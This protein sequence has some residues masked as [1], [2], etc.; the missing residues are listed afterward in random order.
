MHPSR[1]TASEFGLL[2]AHALRRS[3]PRRWNRQ[4]KEQN[5]PLKEHRKRWTPNW[6]PRESRAETRVVTKGMMEMAPQIL[7]VCAQPPRRE[8]H[9]HA[10][11]WAPKWRS[12]RPSYRIAPWI[13]IRFSPRDQFLDGTDHLRG[14]WHR[15]SPC[16]ENAMARRPPDQRF[17][18]RMNHHEAQADGARDGRRARRNRPRLMAISRRCRQPE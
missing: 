13:A 7:P 3:A 14:P 4:L 6:K 17:Q 10:R 8:N 16:K 12:T 5:R 18:L 11:R 9:Q 15:S 2:G 1:R